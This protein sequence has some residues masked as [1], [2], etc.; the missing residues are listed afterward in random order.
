M[1]YEYIH[2]WVRGVH[3]NIQLYFQDEYMLYTLSAAIRYKANLS[4]TDTNKI[5]SPKNP[6]MSFR[7]V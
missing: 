4:K 7:V 3:M 2:A 5:V 1:A 6:K